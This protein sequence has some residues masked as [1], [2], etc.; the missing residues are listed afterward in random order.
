MQRQA[1]QTF[2][3]RPP[4]PGDALL[5]HPSAPHDLNAGRVLTPM[6]AMLTDDASVV[7]CFLWGY[8]AV[9]AWLSGEIPF[10]TH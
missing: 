10:S 9:D 8:M 5:L 6:V 1:R 3:H 4:G 7:S 2:S